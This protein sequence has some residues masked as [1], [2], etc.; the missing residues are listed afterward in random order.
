MGSIGEMKMKRILCYGD[1][2]TWGHIPGV[3]T[4]YPEDVRWTG[5]LAQA[6]GR[7]Y[8]II[9]NG[10]NG[11]STCFDDPYVDYRNGRTGLGY[12]LCAHA[13]LDLVI[14]SLGTNDLK[15]TDARG[16]GRGAEALLRLLS[17]ADANYPAANGCIF[18][19]GTKALLVSPIHL[20]PNIATLRPESSL[21]DRYAETLKFAEHFR[22]SAAA[23]GAEFLDAALYANA[24]E[25]DCVH[26]DEDSHR[27]LGLAI[28]AK[29]RE[30]FTVAD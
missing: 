17:V 7:G 14:I 15:Y 4:R 24:S 21:Y 13:P 22:A 18:P 2:N 8:T 30:I 10:I 6:L 12:A 11:R 26:M 27:T 3:G 29:V 23:Y 19:N 16:A 9:E 1:S 28:A 5:I 20:H 25:R